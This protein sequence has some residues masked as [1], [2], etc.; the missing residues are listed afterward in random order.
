MN[1][2]PSSQRPPHPSVPRTLGGYRVLGVLG[3][4]GMGVVYKAEDVALGRVV[5]LKQI[6]PGLAQSQTFLRRFQTEARVLA[7]M[8][9][10]GIVGIHSLHDVA[11]GLLIDMEFVDGPTLKDRIVQNGAIPWPDALP[12]MKAIL[13]AFND[14]HRAGVVHRD[15]KPQ[16]V[17]LPREGGVK[18]A[19]FGIARVHTDDDETVTKG[20]AGTLKYMSPEQVSGSADLDGRSDLFGLGITFFEMLT[21]A[22]PYDDEASDFEVMRVIVETDLP[23]PRSLRPDVPAELD[24]IVSR[25]LRRDLDQRYAS[26]AETLRDLERFERRHASPSGEPSREPDAASSAPPSNGASPRTARPPHQNDTAGTESG[27]SRRLLAAGVA[28]AVLLIAVAAALLLWPDSSPSPSTASAL[29]AS[30]A[31]STSA[32]SGDASDGR[33]GDSNEDPGAQ[34]PASRAGADLQAGPAVTPETGAG[35]ASP[36]DD[37]SAENR[38]AGDPSAGDASAGTGSAGDAPAER[39]SSTRS[40]TPAPAILN[41]SVP[42]GSVTAN[43]RAVPSSGVVSVAAGLQ[44]LRFTHPDYGAF[45]TTVTAAAGSTAYLVYHFEQPVTINAIGP[46]GNVWINGE[47]RG[48]T[49]LRTRLGPGPHRIELR[50][51]RT[52][53]FTITGGTHSL[54]T[55]DD[56]A[57]SE[58]IGSEVAIDV[59]PGFRETAH[60]VSFTV[61]R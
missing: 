40:S 16:N 24:Q 23:G 58:F 43:G 36:E 45:D 21:G 5:A 18:V 28:V 17:M 10:P 61:A 11:D 4:G 37:A 22:L 19:D 7:R 54:R 55:G 49:P 20:I 35:S 51:D 15:V 27:G 30:T 56:A 44:R 52:D 47:N 48:N 14:A 6:R 2:S 42:G 9:S 38:S 12:L 1:R 59:R 57:S 3:E 34:E 33:A 41:L 29:P 25:M 31:P 46:W 60:T 32:A 39:E 13:R 8:K 26:A 50:I 53:A